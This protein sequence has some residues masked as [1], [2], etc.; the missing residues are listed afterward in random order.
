MLLDMLRVLPKLFSP[1]EDNTVD[2]ILDEEGDQP[3]GGEGE[4]ETLR[5]WEQFKEGVQPYD[6][7]CTCSE[8]AG[9]H[10]G[11]G[12]SYAAQ[13]SGGYFHDPAQSGEEIN[14]AETQNTCVNGCW[15]IG[16]VNTQQL[17]SEQGHRTAD[18][19]A[20]HDDAEN[21]GSE[22][23]SDILRFSCSGILSDKVDRGFVECVG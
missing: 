20:H 13:R 1:F 22:N 3:G 6:A 15:G 23:L 9:D 2:D 12:I 8:N 4:E 17:P 7:Q 18:D 19:R 21:T 16:D 14:V 10:W 5:G 11:D